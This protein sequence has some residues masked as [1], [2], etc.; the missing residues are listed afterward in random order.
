[1][2]LCLNKIEICGKETMIQD[3]FEAII[4]GKGK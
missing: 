2:F 3:E 1:M 4:H